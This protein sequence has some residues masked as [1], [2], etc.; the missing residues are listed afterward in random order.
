MWKGYFEWELHVLFRASILAA[1]SAPGDGVQLR[2]SRLQ[3]QV[4]GKQR[5]QPGLS[6]KSSVTSPA[7]RGRVS[8]RRM[9]SPTSRVHEASIPRG[10]PRPRL[11]TSCGAKL[12]VCSSRKSGEARRT[13]PAFVPAQRNLEIPHAGSQG[14]ASGV[15]QHELGARDGGGNVRGCVVAGGGWRPASG[16]EQACS[17]GKGSWSQACFGPDIAVRIPVW[18]WAP[19]QD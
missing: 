15:V 9:T 2:H 13:A 17:R 16:A 19:L 12:T 4:S 11:R 8:A 14:S 7:P 18:R 1:C 5:R 10:R 3:H 6:A